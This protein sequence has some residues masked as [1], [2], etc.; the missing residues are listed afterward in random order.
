[1]Y[2]QKEIEEKIFELREKGMPYVQISNYMKENGISMCH[3]TVRKICKKVYKE[4]GKKNQKYNTV[5]DRTLSSEDIANL[6]KL[7]YSYKEISDRLKQEGK[8]VSA[9]TLSKKCRKLYNGK[10][11]PSAKIKISSEQI[12]ELREQGMSYEDIS[13][14]F[15][16]Q[17]INISTMTICRRCKDIY[18]EKGKVEQRATYK[19]KSKKSISNEEI[20]NLREKNMSYNEIA[21]SLNSQGKQISVATIRERCKKIYEENGKK[22]PMIDPNRNMTYRRLDEEEK[23][24]DINDEI[25]TLRKQGLSYK[26]ISK[27]LEEQGIKITSV[28][29]CS[30]CKRVFSKKGEKVPR[31]NIEGIKVERD[32]E[33]DSNIG[34][35]EKNKQE[36]QKEREAIDLR[37]IDRKKLIEIILKLRKTRGATNKQ[38]EKV[39]KQYRVNLSFDEKN[40]EEK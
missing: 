40:F 1:M 35:E 25:Y 3:E 20:Y 2:N 30:R 5:S 9:D 22:E 4:K 11:A 8:K 26:A 10:R 37:N 34:V 12:Y 23:G 14:Y 13:K 27:K 16:E 24:I 33:K 6:K 32:K 21:K 38:L 28:T 31:S 15:N 19:A 29:I 39:A 7:G 36:A 18:N 17:G